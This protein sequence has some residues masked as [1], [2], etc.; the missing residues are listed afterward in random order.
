[1]ALRPASETVRIMVTLRTV[2]A[3]HINDLAAA[4]IEDGDFTNH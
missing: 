1:M 4:I 3:N 2:F